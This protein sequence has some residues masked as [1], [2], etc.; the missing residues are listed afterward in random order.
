V[1]RERLDGSVMPSNVIKGT[2]R[3]SIPPIG[4]RLSH[5]SLEHWLLFVFD[6]LVTPAYG[7]LGR[8]LVH[9]VMVADLT[10]GWPKL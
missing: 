6:P 9:L 2:S 4:V 10:T 1:S 8:N 5:L 3:D 7:T